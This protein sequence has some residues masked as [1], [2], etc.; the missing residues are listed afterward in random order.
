MIWKKRK[1]KRRKVD[2]A[3]LAARKAAQQVQAARRREAFWI[4]IAIVA[5]LAFMMAFGALLIRT[6]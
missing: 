4:A 6:L 1:P 5:I 3:R 2:P